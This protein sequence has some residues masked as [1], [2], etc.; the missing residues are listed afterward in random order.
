M[1]RA[2]QLHQQGSCSAFGTRLSFGSEASPVPLG[3][4]Q[5]WPHSHMIVASPQFVTLANAKCRGVA[6]KGISTRRSEHWKLA[7]SKPTWHPDVATDDPE[8]QEEA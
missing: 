3:L 5:M 1:K 7:K 8:A 2:C 6:L 4:F